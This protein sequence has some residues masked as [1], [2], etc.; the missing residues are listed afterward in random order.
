MCSKL[1]SI[2]EFRPEKTVTFDPPKLM[3]V[4]N[5]GDLANPDICWYRLAKVIYVNP[6]LVSNGVLAMGDG[7]D[8]H[9]MGVPW[10]HCAECCTTLGEED[11]EHLVQGIKEYRQASGE[12]SRIGAAKL[13]SEMATHK[14][15][16]R[17]LSDGNGQVMVARKMDGITP[18]QWGTSFSYTI[19]LDDVSVPCE[20]GVAVGEQYVKVRKYGDTKSADPTREYLGFVDDKKVELATYCNVLRWLSD[21]LC[22]LADVTVTYGLDEVWITGKGGNTI[23][24]TPTEVDYRKYTEK[25][26]V[27]P[28]NMYTVSAMLTGC[29]LYDPDIRMDEYELVMNRVGYLDYLAGVLNNSTGKPSCSAVDWNSYVAKGINDAR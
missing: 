23:K 13:T 22:N 18:L 8:A 14:E 15:L 12:Q 4:W 24:L 3:Y 29:L 17:W 27:I 5:D 6:S 2:K 28:S 19:D 16:S 21:H 7:A 9:N 1:T 25:M 10:D 26:S 11:R 20:G